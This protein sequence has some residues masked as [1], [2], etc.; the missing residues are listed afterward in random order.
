MAALGY[1]GPILIRQSVRFQGAS[2]EVAV[3]TASNITT[4]GVQAFLEG[5]SI[6]QTEKP[7]NKVPGLY[8]LTALFV[9]G[10]EPLDVY[11]QYEEISPFVGADY[12]PWNRDTSFMQAFSAFQFDNEGIMTAYPIYMD[13][14]GE[15]RLRIME[16]QPAFLI[17]DING[18]GASEVIA[19]ISAPSS[20]MSWCKVF[21]FTS[22]FPEEYLHVSLN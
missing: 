16:T 19:C 21:T 2:S 17:A 15:A 10:Q 9:Q 8:I 13:M 5:A 4:N 14:T 3:V 6:C 12:L 22:G 20:L 7:A 18:D 11:H 1:D